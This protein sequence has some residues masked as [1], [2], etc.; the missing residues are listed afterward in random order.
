MSA[1]SGELRALDAK[2]VCGEHACRLDRKRIS[3]LCRV[4]VPDVG[5]QA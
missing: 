3:R 1:N 5:A 4:P 2:L